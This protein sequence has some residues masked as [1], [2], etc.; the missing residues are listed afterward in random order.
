MHNLI[1][2]VTKIGI[3]CGIRGNKKRS[4][5]WQRGERD[6]KSWWSGE[7]CGSCD[8]H[9][10]ISLWQEWDSCTR[11]VYQCLN[12][13]L[14]PKARHKNSW[15]IK[16]NEVD[17]LGDHIGI[18]YGTVNSGLRARWAPV[19]LMPTWGWREKF[20]LWIRI[21]ISQKVPFEELACNSLPGSFLIVFSINSHIT[22]IIKD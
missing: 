20:L 18:G 17:V 15:N 12:T 7:K 11:K 9:A 4:G 5:R 2:V 14:I 8:G 13:P 1:Q 16:K 22:I 19:A 3:F 10:R 6:R 21:K